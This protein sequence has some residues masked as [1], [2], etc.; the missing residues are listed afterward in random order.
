LLGVQTEY[1]GIVKH[2]P[3]TSRTTRRGARTQRVRVDPGERD[4]SALRAVA[5][6][7]FPLVLADSGGDTATGSAIDGGLP[8]IEPAPS[9]PNPDGSRRKS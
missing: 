2:R 3:G 5:E 7:V 1:P 4:G 9:A 8:P 6:L